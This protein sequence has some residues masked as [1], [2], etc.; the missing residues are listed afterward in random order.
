MCN[1]SRKLKASLSF[2]FSDALGVVAAGADLL[3]S[4]PFF[5]V[6]RWL[7]HGTANRLCAATRIT[8]SPPLLDPVKDKNQ[9]LSSLPP[10]LPR[11]RLIGSLTSYLIQILWL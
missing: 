11:S 3:A 8:H 6:A 5:L 10:S 9:P 2:F 7:K 1:L 4:Q